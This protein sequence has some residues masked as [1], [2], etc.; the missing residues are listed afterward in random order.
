MAR[1]MLNEY[2]TPDR[3][4]ADTINTTCH[5]INRLYLHKF[6][7]KTSY[8]LLTGKRPNVSYFK[9]FGAKCFI[10]DKHR[11]SKFAPKAHEGFY[12]G[13]ASNSHAYRVFNNFTWRVEETVDVEFEESNGSQ[14]E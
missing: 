5:A 8:E 13:Y 3:F 9:V 4:W 12:L 1:T 11:T 14:V 7:K 10:L 2:N 6:F